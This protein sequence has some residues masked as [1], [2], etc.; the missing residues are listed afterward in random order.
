MPYNHQWGIE[1][2]YNNNNENNK[3]NRDVIHSR[4]LNKIIWTEARLVTYATN[5]NNFLTNIVI[6]ELL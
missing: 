6:S 4:Y 2:Q 1:E 3:K 5:M